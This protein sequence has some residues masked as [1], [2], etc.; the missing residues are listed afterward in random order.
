MENKI[1]TGADKARENGFS[2]YKDWILAWAVKA[3][4]PWNGKMSA[5]K[6]IAF[7]DYSRLLAECPCGNV[8]YVD[9]TEDFFYC[10]LCGNQAN[11]GSAMHVVFPNNLAEIEKELMLRPV[12]PPTSKHLPDS[13]KVLEAFPVYPM[14]SRSWRPGESV[15]DLRAQR[16]LVQEAK[17]L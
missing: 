2:N 1:Y 3:S 11:K 7:V 4:H 6:V 17:K 14:L 5:K 9:P 16:K 13:Q 15:E 12:C 10:R 8:I